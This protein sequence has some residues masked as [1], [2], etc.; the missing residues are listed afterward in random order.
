MNGMI[1]SAKARSELGRSVGPIRP[2]DRALGPDLTGTSCETS[3]IDAY[4]LSRLPGRFG[5]H[6]TM[7]HVAD[8][9][10]SPEASYHDAA[11]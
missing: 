1:H 4:A 11:F 6:G 8:V 2:T 10:G 5:G 9:A 3:R 7:P